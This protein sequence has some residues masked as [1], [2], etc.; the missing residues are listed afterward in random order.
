MGGRPGHQR[1]RVDRNVPALVHH[2]E[3]LTVEGV[4]EVD[5]DAVT[6]AVGVGVLDKVE[7]GVLVTVTDGVGVL[8]AVEVDVGVLDAVAVDDEVGVDVGVG[9]VVLLGEGDADGDHQA[10]GVGTCSGSWRITTG[11][12]S[13]GSAENSRPYDSWNACRLRTRLP[14]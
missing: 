6:E 7:L 4:A 1:N 11:A 3:S 2:R 14:S 10:S 13:L 8:E 9:V 12:R 5:A